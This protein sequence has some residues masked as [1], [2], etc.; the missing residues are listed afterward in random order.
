M[1]NLPPYKNWIPPLKVI[2]HLGEYVFWGTQFTCPEFI[3]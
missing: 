1:N 2:N 3:V